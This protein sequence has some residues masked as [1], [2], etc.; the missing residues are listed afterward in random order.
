[1]NSN[2]REIRRLNI[3][4]FCNRRCLWCCY[5]CCYFLLFGQRVSACTFDRLFVRLPSLCLRVCLLCTRLS[6]HCSAV[7]SVVTF[8]A[9]YIR[10]LF[11]LPLKFRNV[12]EH[13]ESRRS[14][15]CNQNIKEDISTA[16]AV[17][18]GFETKQN[19]N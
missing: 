10:L 18:V 13:T 1:M 15:A 7:H 9:G 19:I 6:R 5:R 2:S 14:L 11:K 3:K 12:L 17:L 4:S 16:F 8:C